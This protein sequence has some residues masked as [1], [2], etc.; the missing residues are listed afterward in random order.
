MPVSLNASERFPAII[1]LGA[2]FR[3]EVLCVRVCVCEWGGG[4]VG[5]RGWVGGAGAGGR[6][7]HEG[8]WH[9]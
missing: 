5:V 4:Q 2:N 8:M 7:V 1:D 9:E 6:G 3:W